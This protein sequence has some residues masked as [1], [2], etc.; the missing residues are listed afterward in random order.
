VVSQVRKLTLRGLALLQGLAG[1]GIPGGTPIETGPIEWSPELAEAIRQ[2]LDDLDQVREQVARLQADDLTDEQCARLLRETLAPTSDDD[3]RALC[4]EDPDPP[5]EG[6]K[7]V[8]RGLA[9]E[10]LKAR[11]ALRKRDVECFHKAA[12]ITE[13]ECEL[14]RYKAVRLEQ[15]LQDALYVKLLDLTGTGS[16]REAVDWV[17]DAK[18]QL[19]WLRGLKR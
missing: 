5:E 7:L 13:L 2:V 17:S 6:H 8:I 1:R 12:E 4:A 11:A 14:D 15:T 19:T 10:L 9:A 18:A 16:I 3:L